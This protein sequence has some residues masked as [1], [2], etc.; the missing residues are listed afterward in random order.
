VR[1]SGQLGIPLELN[2]ALT[3]DAQDKVLSD[4]S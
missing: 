1:I 4:K 3:C 2:G